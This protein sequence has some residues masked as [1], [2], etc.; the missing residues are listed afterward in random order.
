MAVALTQQS[1][2]PAG[3]AVAYKTTTDGLAVSGNTAP[4]GPGLALLVK[5]GS[6]APITVNMVIPAGITLDGIAQTTPLPVAVATGAD[7]VI[8]L[9]PQRYADPV[10]GLA[11][12]G[13]AA[14][15]T[16]VNVAVINTN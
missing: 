13:F 3:A 12:F 2:P 8:P 14:T 1:F 10:T 16:S 15:P 4:T 7:Q 6:G 11:T 5:N 9:R